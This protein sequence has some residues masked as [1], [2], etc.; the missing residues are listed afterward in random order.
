M[1]VQHPT[2]ATLEL[3][4]PTPQDHFSVLAT[5]V[6]PEMAGLLV[7]VSY[8]QCFNRPK[9]CYYSSVIN[10]ETSST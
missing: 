7:T 3:P 6:S 4:V 10:L 2:H 5:V 8:Q 9:T 1:N